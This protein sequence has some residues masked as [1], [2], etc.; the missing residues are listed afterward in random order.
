MNKKQYQCPRC[1]VVMPDR[2][3]YAVCIACGRPSFKSEREVHV[4]WKKHNWTA[5]QQIKKIME[6]VGEVAEALTSGDLITAIKE[7]KDVEQTCKT[8][9]AI[10]AYDWEQEY[11][12]P[13][14]IKR[15]EREHIEKLERKGY[16][17]D[18]QEYM[19][20]VLEAGDTD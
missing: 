20:K 13:C 5:A 16:L 3:D 15:F 18:Q 11:N 8:M 9:L 19:D 12:S 4:D 14:P 2:Y 6:E 10:L 7:T 1:K 17:S